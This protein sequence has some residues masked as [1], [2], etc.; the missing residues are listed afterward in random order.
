MK[1]GV[2]ILLRVR[3][4]RL[5]FSGS[6]RLCLEETRFPEAPVIEGL[7]RIYA[8]INW[9]FLKENAKFVTEKP[10]RGTY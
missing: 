4:M 3:Y 5:E 2:Y 9:S 8:A 6:K 10:D 7:V 1:L